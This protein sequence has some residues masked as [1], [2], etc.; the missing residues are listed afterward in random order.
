MLYS[1]DIDLFFLTLMYQQSGIDMSSNVMLRTNYREI[2]SLSPG[3][4][5]CKHFPVLLPGPLTTQIL[6]Q[7]LM[8]ING[9][10]ISQQVTIFLVL[11]DRAVSSQNQPFGGMLTNG[12]K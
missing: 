11:K 10:T 8:G 1:Y 2:I 7:P 4:E 5:Y 6:V 3:N 12:L 9:G